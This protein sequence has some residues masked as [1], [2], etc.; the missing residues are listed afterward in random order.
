MP[1]LTTTD[2]F[3]IIDTPGLNDANIDTK[4]WVDRFNDAKNGA[5]P[6]PLAL[7]ILLFKAGNRP[8]KDDYVVL[9]VCA[10]AIGNLHPKNIVVVF[11][12]CD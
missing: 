10:K 4:D 3:N 5:G 1:E 9:G 7:A 8:S 12:H 6:Q 11:T 2:Q